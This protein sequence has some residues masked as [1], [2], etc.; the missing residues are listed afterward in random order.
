MPCKSVRLNLRDLLPDTLDVADLSLT[1]K[2]TLGTD[3]TSDL[4][5]LGGEDG[6]LVNHAVDGVHEVEDF[7]RDW[8]ARDL[9]RQVAFRHSTLNHKP[10]SP[11]TLFGTMN[12]T[13]CR[14]GDRPHL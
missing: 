11:C 14:L 3:F 13:H 2:L 1:T 4:L 12:R 8:Y 5:D 10:V 6:Q 7:S 9:L